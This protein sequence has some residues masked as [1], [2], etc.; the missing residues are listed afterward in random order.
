MGYSTLK[1]ECLKLLKGGRKSEKNCSPV[2][3]WL[4]EFC[5]LSFFSWL[6][7]GCSP[8]SISKGTMLGTAPGGLGTAAFWTTDMG[9]L[10]TV[11]GTVNVGVIIGMVLGC[12]LNVVVAGAR[13]GVDSLLG[14]GAGLRGGTGEGSS[15]A[16][17]L[18][19][20]CSSIL[21]VKRSFWN[22]VPKI[23]VSRFVRGMVNWRKL[24]R[25]RAEG[26]LFFFLK[27]PTHD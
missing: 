17:E 11:W 21:R 24:F 6:F 1:M 5:A 26:G 18:K 2:L 22:L 10:F 3:F 4:F 19:N 7:C 23:I 14:G 13:A 27:L 12:M 8:F 16:S 9:W 15:S 20:Y 25:G